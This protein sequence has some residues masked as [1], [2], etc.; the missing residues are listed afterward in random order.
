MYKDSWAGHWNG[1]TPA[2]DPHTRAR[3]TIKPTGT[4]IRVKIPSRKNG[5]MT[6][7][8]SSLEGD[9]VF[10]F[11]ASHHVLRY[12]DQPPTIYY[13]DGAKL[14]RY[15]PD[16]ELELD[17]G[18]LLTVE[19]KP[20]SSLACEKVRHQLDCIEKHFRAS[21]VNYLVLTEE[22]ILQEPRLSNLRKIC[23]GAQRIWPTAD[24]IQNALNQHYQHFPTTFQHANELLQKHNLNVYS[25]FVKGA[26]TMD[27]NSLINPKT[28][29]HITKENDNAHFWIG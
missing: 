14:R 17:T 12:R 11:E 3:E 7:A 20:T 6:R 28:T 22:V 26:L 19:V 9:A 23:A 27:L 29:V 15:T 25:L 13:P 16:F 1:Q 8:E 4:T 21:G 10:L 2:G 5:R 24:A 18:E